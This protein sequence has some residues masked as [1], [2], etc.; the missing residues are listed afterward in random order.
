MSAAEQTALMEKVSL[1][2][3][4]R[5]TEAEWQAREKAEVQKYTEKGETPPW[6]HLLTGMHPQVRLGTPSLKE[7]AETEEQMRRRLPRGARG[8]A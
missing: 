6:H 3:L 4:L 1:G 5:A 2:N 8:G 7:P